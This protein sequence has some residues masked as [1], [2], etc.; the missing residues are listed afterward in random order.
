MC[1][2]V[3]VCVYPCMYSPKVYVSPS[4]TATY[5]GCG[6]HSAGCLLFAACEYVVDLLS[7]NAV[8]WQR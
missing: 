3:C 1:V 6:V 8:H 2:C 4:F 7:T 5:G